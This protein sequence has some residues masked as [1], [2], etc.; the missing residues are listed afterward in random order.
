M[1]GVKHEQCFPIHP[2]QMALVQ[3][4]SRGMLA[5]T[6][7]TDGI[8]IGDVPRTADLPITVAE[9]QAAYTTTIK[10]KCHWGRT[11]HIRS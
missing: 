7:R 3:H 2:Q 9:G 6:S 5:A 1:K 10:T 11:D 4:S 8:R